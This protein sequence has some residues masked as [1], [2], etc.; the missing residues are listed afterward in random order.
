M[1]VIGGG[2]AG[3]EAALQLAGKKHKVDLIEMRP[4]SPTPAHQTGSLAELVC[5]NSLKS[6]RIDNASGLLKKELKILGC[7]LLDIASESSVPAG[8]ALAVDRDLF[9]RKVTEAIEREPLIDLYREEKTGLDF[10]GC[11]II[12][13]GPLTSD[14][15][16]RAISN[17]FSR[18]HLHFYDAISIS[19]SIETA[20]TA[21]M[22]KASRYGKGGA[23]YYN[24][25][26]NRE[27]YLALVSY[28]LKAPKTEKH[29]FES[30]KCFEA[31]LPIEESASRGVD[32]PRFG[33]MKPRGLPDPETGSEPYAVIQLRQETV[34]G[35]MFGLVGFQ[36]RLT[37]PA[38]K[39]MLR[40][41]PGLENAE[42]LR[43]GS[44]HR[45]T[46][47][48]T[49]LLLDRR[50]MST[51]REGLFFAGQIVGVEGYVESIGNGL[52]A[53]LN[54]DAFLNGRGPV[55]LPL[56]TIL[57]G[58]QRYLADTSTGFQP[59]NANFGLLPMVAGQKKDRKIRKAEASIMAIEDFV[60]TCQNHTSS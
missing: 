6:T 38:Q 37:R 23:D 1:T 42:I 58:L 48:E 52:L 28:L 10:E 45:N 33:I 2:L 55:V 20:D 21:K 7:R 4:S 39:E 34:E 9:S 59:V 36:T 57:G 11:C 44:I 17:H 46:F 47:M 8:H 19:I 60:K 15:L 56:E 50:Q 31:C 40:L 54:V 25:P 43:W 13:T 22:Y 27:K 49:P 53:A 41:I 29:H 18:N 16:S 3:C 35:S 14:S 5:S 30:S 32:T 24:I 51:K 26:L 12:A